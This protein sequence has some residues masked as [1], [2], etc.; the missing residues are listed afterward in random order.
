[1]TALLRRPGLSVSHHTVDRLM[2]D[3][4]LN[5]GPASGLERDFTAAVPNR[6]W[7]AEFTYCRTWAGWVFVAC[8]VDVYAQRMRRVHRGW[9]ASTTRTCDLVLT[10][11]QMAVGQR[12]HDG[13]PVVPSK[14]IHHHDAGSQ[15]TALRFTENLALEGTAPSIGSVGDAL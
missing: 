13:R 11:L 3:L 1:M 12:E 2:R 5:P 4:R 8:V 7:V 15:D 14:L 6:Q 9:H 10:C